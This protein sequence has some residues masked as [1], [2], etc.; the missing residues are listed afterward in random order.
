MY[1]EQF[2]ILED[3]LKS[4]QTQQIW[5]IYSLCNHSPKFENL[6]ICRDILKLFVKYL[7]DEK[8][9]LGAEIVYLLM[10]DV[11]SDKITYKLVYDSDLPLN[12]LKVDNSNI[13]GIVSRKSHEKLQ[14]ESN[15]RL[16]LSQFQIECDDIYKSIKAK[17]SLSDKLWISRFS[18]ISNTKSYLSRESITSSNFTNLEHSEV[19]CK[20]EPYP[21]LFNNGKGSQDRIKSSIRENI[22]VENEKKKENDHSMDIEN[23]TDPYPMKHE[24]KNENKVINIKDNKVDVSE[25]GTKKEHN[26]VD[27]NEDVINLFKDEENENISIT[28]EFVQ[29]EDNKLKPVKRRK[30]TKLKICSDNNEDNKDD[31]DKIEFDPLEVEPIIQSKVRKERMYKDAKTG[32]LVVE[33]DV[34]FVMEKE[35]KISKLGEKNLGNNDNA[36]LKKPNKGKKSH[37]LSSNTNSGTSK[38]QTLNS[39]FKITKTTNK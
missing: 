29:N 39:F 35:N 18:N 26:K 37:S 2:H 31:K 23:N 7:L 20:T 10:G 36:T 1:R 11:L 38:Q 16:N 9:D 6:E 3:L 17:N 30:T 33:D 13:Y 22:S 25:L 24:F 19:K 21:L 12:G 34:D 4:S 5:S 14:Q 15:L 28:D 27:E 32:Y 8:K